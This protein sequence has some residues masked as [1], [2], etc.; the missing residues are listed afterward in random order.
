M[1][2][3]KQEL[4]YQ[5]KQQLTAKFRPQVNCESGFSYFYRNKVDVTQLLK[6]VVR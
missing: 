3:T 1:K 2:Q 6:K 5:A 4:K